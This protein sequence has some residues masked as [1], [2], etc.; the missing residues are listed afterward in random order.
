MTCET[1]IYIAEYYHRNHLPVPVDVQ[2]RLL[3]A[4]VDVQR[5]QHQ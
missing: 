3:E 4:G 2:A 1:L 5:Y